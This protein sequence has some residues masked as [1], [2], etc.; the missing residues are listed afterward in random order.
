MSAAHYIPRRLND[1]PRLFFWDL[2]VAMVF[3]SCLMMGLFMNAPISGILSASVLGYKFGKL[4]SGKHPAFAIHMA[5][6]Y[7]PLGSSLK[8]LP[9]SHLRE[10]NG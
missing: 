1:P 5:Y 8:V 6:W 9:P 7:I 4:K 10:L 3:L 2:D